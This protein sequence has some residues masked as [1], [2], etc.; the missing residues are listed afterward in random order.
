[1]RASAVAGQFYSSAKVALLEE[2]ESCF[3]KGAGLPGKQKK[4]NVLGAISPHAGYTYSGP[5]ASYVY[6]ELAESTFP[7]LFVILGV[8]HSGQKTCVSLEDWETPLG[9]VKNDLEFSKALE[10]DVDENAHLDEHSIEVQ[11]PFLQFASK[12]IK[13]VPIIVNE[14]KGIAEKIFSTA[15]KQKKNIVVIASSDFTHYGINYGYLPFLSNVKENLYKLDKGAIE[16]ILKLDVEGF[17]KY[18]EQTEATI[19]GFKPILVLME[20]LKLAKS[21]EGKLLHYTTSGDVVSDFTNA[22]GYAAI[23]FY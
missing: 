11:L 20:Y 21:N 22:V 1:M 7:D 10:I 14:T 12:E 2:L 19:C 9:V 16:N 4:Q 17:R 13:F 3:K 8:P 5:T 6:K 15:K 18:V 23:V